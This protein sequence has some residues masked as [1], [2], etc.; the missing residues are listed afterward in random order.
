MSPARFEHLLSLVGP[1]I[2]KKGHT[3]KG[4]HICRTAFG[5]HNPIPI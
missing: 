1:I 4:I 2:Q 5:D 3:I